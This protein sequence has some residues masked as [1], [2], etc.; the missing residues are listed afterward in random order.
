MNTDL[1]T[2][3]S[4]RAMAKLFLI[5]LCNILPSLVKPG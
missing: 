1:I 4:P 5:S 2:H 3:N